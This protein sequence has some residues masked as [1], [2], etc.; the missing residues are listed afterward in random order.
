MHFSEIFWDYRHFNST[1]EAML[2]KRLLLLEGSAA[3]K[4]QDIDQTFPAFVEKSAVL[5]RRLYEAGE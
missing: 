4:R 2:F 3:Y 5:T 1:V